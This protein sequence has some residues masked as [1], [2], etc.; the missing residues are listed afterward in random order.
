MKE[1]AIVVRNLKKELKGHKILN[2]IAFDVEKN[3]FFGIVGRNASGKSMLYKALAGLITV[4][5]GEI[6]IENIDIVKKRIL[7]DDLGFLIEAPGFLPQ[8]SGFK[9]LKFLASIRDKITEEEIK[10]AMQTV[11]LDPDDKRPYRKYSLGMKQKL[12]IAQAIMENPKILLLDEPMNNLDYE[13]I[14][15]MRELFKKLNN[16]GTTILIT[17]HNKEDIEILCNKKAELEN[18]YLKQVD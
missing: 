6:I 15:S 9:N 4:N 5:E 1:T 14:I 16:N 18:G 13:S 2:N 10:K 17:S 12:G 7:P 8:F 3:D 11:G